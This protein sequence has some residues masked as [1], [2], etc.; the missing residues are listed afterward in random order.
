[1]FGERAA[2]TSGG[3]GAE[4]GLDGAVR[5]P[6]S[7]VEITQDHV[8]CVRRQIGCERLE[9]RHAA[10][11]ELVACS[12]CNDGLRGRVHQGPRA[13]VSGDPVVARLDELNR[14]FV[15]AATL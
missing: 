1:M 4:Y 13:N 2:L 6:G 9:L 11:P 3:E 14:G 10:A 12:A 8:A 7:Q 15:A 5:F